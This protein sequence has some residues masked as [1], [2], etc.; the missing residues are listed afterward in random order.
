MNNNFNN[1]SLLFSFALTLA[2][3][4]SSPIAN[5][6]QQGTGHAASHSATASS[7]MTKAQIQQL[8]ATAM[9]ERA[10]GQVFSAIQTFEYLLSQRPSLNRARL[11]LAVSYNH[12]SRYKAAIQQLNTVLNDPRTPDKVRLVVLAY[13]GQI[14]SNRLEPAAKNQFSYY[15]K[16]GVLYNTNIN[17]APLQGSQTY[18]IPAGQNISSP[19]LETFFSFSHRYSRKKPVDVADSAARFQWQNQLS[20]TG[21]N[22]TRNNNYSLNIVSLST[23]PALIV[24][25]HWRG[26]INLQLDQTYFG[27]STLGTFTSLNPQVTFDLGKH[28]SLLLEASYTDNNFTRTTDNGR[29]GDT[30]LAGIAYTTLLNGVNNGLETGFRLIRQAANDNQFGF[31]SY[32]LYFGGFIATAPSANIYLNVHLQH[33]NF[34]AADT[35]SGI[36]R[37]ELEG[38]YTMGYNYDFSAGNLKGWTMNTHVS[39]TKNNSNVGAFSYNRTIV[40]INLARYFQ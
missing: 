11:E 34:D 9:K 36:T 14:K 10:S 26:S 15:A 31:N 18:N 21:N 22:Y 25:G 23:G 29:D 12:A 38:R 20:W 40:G 39:F 35:L 1:K 17:F 33:Y 37:D 32:Q 19:G 24:A 30:V 4:I 8:F 28:Q 2:L 7:T 6:Q 13:L 3:A 16:M 5:A 27:T